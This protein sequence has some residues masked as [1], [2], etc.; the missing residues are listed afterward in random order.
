[1]L[2]YKKTTKIIRKAIGYKNMYQFINYD[3]YGN[4]ESA[5]ID[6]LE[7]GEKDVL[8]ETGGIILEK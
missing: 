6:V 5:F 7:S 2:K 4:I 8:R 3:E 1:M